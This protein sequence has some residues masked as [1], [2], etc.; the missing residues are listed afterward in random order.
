MQVLEGLWF[1]DARMGISQ[2]G[3]D[4][5]KSTESQLSIRFNPVV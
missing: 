3:F 4:Q 5:I 2:D 1:P